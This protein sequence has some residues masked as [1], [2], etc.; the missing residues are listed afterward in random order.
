MGFA[1]IIKPIYQTHGKRN[2]VFGF[3]WCGWRWKDNNVQGFM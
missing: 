1:D 3:V 2:N